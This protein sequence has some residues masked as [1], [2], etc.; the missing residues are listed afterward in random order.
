MLMRQSRDYP[1]CQLQANIADLPSTVTFCGDKTITVKK[2]H[3]LINEMSTYVK[4]KSGEVFD[5]NGTN[6]LISRKYNVFLKI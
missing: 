2:E 4:K 3:R 1:N 6:V 5:G